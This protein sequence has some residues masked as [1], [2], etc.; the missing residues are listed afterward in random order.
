MKNEEKR[1]LENAKLVFEKVFTN[2]QNSHILIGFINDVLELD[3]TEV[4]TIEN[5]YNMTAFHE[6]SKKP[7][8]RQ[9]HVSVLAKRGDGSQVIIE[10]QIYGQDLVRDQALLHTLKD[11]V[12]KCVLCGMG[13]SAKEN[14]RGGQEHLAYIP[15]YCVNI[16]VENE[17]PKDAISL[18]EFT[19]YDEKHDICIV[20]ERSEDLVTMVCLELNKPSEEMKKNARAW[21]DYLRTGEVTKEAPAYLQKVCIQT[22]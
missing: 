21:M 6:E 20:N 12:M 17:F 8:D 3:V 18:R 10:M 13:K 4:G 1:I 16:M 7:D 14:L 22:E 9:Q 15:V 5:T 19:F 2:P 11:Y